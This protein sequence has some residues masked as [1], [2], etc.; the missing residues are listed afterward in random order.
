MPKPPLIT[1]VSDT[2]TAIV[3]ATS[4]PQMVDPANITSSTQTQPTVEP[5][6]PQKLIQSI[7]VQTKEQSFDIINQLN[8]M[9]IQIP[10]FQGIKD[11]PI[12]GKAIREALLKNP[13]RKKKDPT[14]VHVVGQ[15]ADIMLGKLV[16][17]KYFD[18]GSPVV[19]VIINGQSIKN[20]SIDLGAAI[21]IMTKD[22]IKKLNIKGLRAT[23]IVMQLADS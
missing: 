8:N 1:E 4:Q 22:T 23:P 19:N 12:Y 14:I 9:H 3:P 15:L 6:F 13:G 16:I 10:L 11:V 7:L 21:N 18:P 5:P 2:P 17:P 20:S